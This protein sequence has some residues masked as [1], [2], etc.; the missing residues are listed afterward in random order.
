MPKLKPHKGTQKRVRITRNKKVIRLKAND[1]HF[2]SKKSE[3]RKRSLA[4]KSIVKGS[5]ARTV[6]R[7]L[8]V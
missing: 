1:S 7:A 3:S 2:L 5:I 4:K 8:G 6:K